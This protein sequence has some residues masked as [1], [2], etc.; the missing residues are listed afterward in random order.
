MTS[1]I[2]LQETL[3]KTALHKLKRK[4]PYAWDLNVYRGCQH[5]CIYCYAQDGHARQRRG[6]F[7]QNIIIKTNVAEQLDSEL[8]SPF[9]KRE[10]I[11]IGGVTDS[12]Q[13]AGA[14]YTLMP[15]IL[16][17]CIRHRT[18]VIISTKSDLILRDKDLIAELAEI[19]Y[20]N[21]ALTVT[22]MNDRIDLS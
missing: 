17:T 5:G 2:T 14:L 11:N 1:N 15:E 13:P 3:C 19:T 10:I 4:H 21:V 16:R 6:S 22:V 18:P 7:S 9:W 8:S 20:V 12:Y